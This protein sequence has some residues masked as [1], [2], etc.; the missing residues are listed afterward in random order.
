[1][2]IWLAIHTSWVFQQIKKLK[3]FFFLI[4][5]LSNW[6]TQISVMTRAVGE[7]KLSLIGGMAES[8]HVVISKYLIFEE[9]ILI[10][11]IA[12]K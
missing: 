5:L 10:W 1:M 7:L 12:V 8:R 6:R 2:S 11:K 9:L 3:H 4:L